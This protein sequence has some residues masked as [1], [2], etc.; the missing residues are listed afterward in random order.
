MNYTRPTHMRSPLRRLKGCP[1]S[2]RL[3]RLFG[4]KG[5]EQS[6]FSNLPVKEANQRAFFKNETLKDAEDWLNWFAAENF[7]NQREAL[8]IHTAIEAIYDPCMQ[9]IYDMLGV[10]D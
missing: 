2:A 7:V 3:R 5:G 4:L 10:D 8:E 1:I 6:V 9:R